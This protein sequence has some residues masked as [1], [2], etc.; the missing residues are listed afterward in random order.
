MNF[1]LHEFLVSIFIFIF[2]SYISLILFKN[3]PWRTSVRKSKIPFYFAIASA[4][5][6]LGF[7]VSLRYILGLPFF[8]IL[9]LIG[10][11]FIVNKKK[12]IKL[13]ALNYRMK[14]SIF[15][16]AVIFLFTVML[17]NASY[18]PLL[19]NDSM[20]YALAAKELVYSNFF[21]YP[22]LNSSENFTGFYGPWTHPPIFTSL[23]AF[24]SCNDTDLT[25]TG[26]MR[27]VSVWFF[28]AILL[29]SKAITDFFTPKFSGIAPLLICSVPLLFFG[30][31]SSLS[32]T[33]F[34]NS[35]FLVFA[36]LLFLDFRKQKTFIIF[37]IILGLSMWAHSVCILLPLFGFVGI[38]LLYKD[39][40]NFNF[41]KNL[42]VSLLILIVVFSFPLYNNITKL[43]VFI[44]DNP[45]VF[46][47]PL[48][49]WKEYFFVVRELNSPTELFFNGWLKG[50]TFIESYGLIFYIYIFS[51]IY[52]RKN[53]H[54]I[55][56]KS[57]SNL[58]NNM[59][60]FSFVVVML[61]FF[62][63]VTTSLLGF[64]DFI[65]NERYQLIILP[66]ANIS[67]AVFLARFIS[68]L[69]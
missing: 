58:F 8:T 12:L 36:S 56:N 48:L 66:F 3:L 22:V 65:K 67:G 1:S 45:L 25:F 62:L 20:E 13:D 17:L 50:F 7:A 24:F 47:L 4:P 44:S 40:L 10:T 57:K 39:M 31:D 5:L 61:Y 27:L 52:F 21:N 29:I 19:Q 69:K 6:L 46:Q 53:Y 42:G 64:T 23:I 30:A 16:Y 59:L 9:L 35:S 43:N 28:L 38:L 41:I 15:D 60:I 11:L 55:A 34:V 14:I 54:Q 18:F 2:S 33:L 32:D 51:I 49:G 68:R 26:S 63:S 37:P